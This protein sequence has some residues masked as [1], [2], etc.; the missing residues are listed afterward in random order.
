MNK[1]RLIGLCEQLVD[2]L[3]ESEK[4]SDKEWS[5]LW[6]KKQIPQE[7]IQE[8]SKNRTKIIALCEAIAPDSANTKSNDLPKP[9]SIV[10]G[11]DQITIF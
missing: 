2:V 11:Y 9:G 4:I 7:L 10:F 1:K 6:N 3:D 5:Y 8:R